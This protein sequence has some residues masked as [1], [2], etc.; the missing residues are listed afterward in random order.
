MIIFCQKVLI[1]VF[2]ILMLLFG[3]CSS[4]ESPRFYLLNPLP[5]R[6]DVQEQPSGPCVKLGIGRVRMPEY[7][8]RPQIVTRTSR[9]EL[10][11]ARYDRWAEPLSDTFPRVIAQNLSRMLCA[12]TVSLYPWRP[13]AVHSYRLDVEVMRMDGTLGGEVVLEAWWSLSGGTGRKILVEKRSRFSEPAQSEG[14]D[15][16]VEALDRAIASLS[17]G[18]AQ[19][20]AAIASE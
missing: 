1:G 19:A 16:Y 13:S 8:D 18:I 15:A 7:V 17:R 14:Y 11:L 5:E 20:I 9:S 10:A 4:S 12:D 3:A 2:C 6:T